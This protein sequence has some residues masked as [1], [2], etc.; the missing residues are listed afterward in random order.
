MI[1]ASLANRLLTC[2][3]VAARASDADVRWA[4]SKWTSEDRPNSLVGPAK[5]FEREVAAGE[6]RWHTAFEVACWIA[7][8][9]RL[10]FYPLQTGLDTLR[11]SFLE[12]LRTPPATKERADWDEGTWGRIVA[13][14]VGRAMDKEI[15]L[16]EERRSTSKDTGLLHGGFLDLLDP[17][18]ADHTLDQS[19]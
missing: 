15:E 18:A 8:E 1:P 16:L 2:F 6:S 17:D 9:A 11:T 10:G 7:E 3:S 5:Y 4:R 13:G 12:V 19:S 14:A